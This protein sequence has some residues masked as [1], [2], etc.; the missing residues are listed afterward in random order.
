MQDIIDNTYEIVRRLEH[1]QQISIYLVRNINNNTLYAAKVRLNNIDVNQHE[2]QMCTNVS[3]INNPYIARLVNHG[4]GNIIFQGNIQNNQNYLIFDYYPH[5]LYEYIEKTG[6]FTEKHAKLIFDQIL[7]GV[8]ALHQA[9]ICHRYLAIDNILFDNNYNV[10]IIDFHIAALLQGN[11]NFNDNVGRESYSP[12]QMIEHLPYNGIKADIFSLGII[13]FIL[14]N[15]KTPFQSASYEDPLYKLIKNKEFDKYFLQVYKIMFVNNS[16][17][18]KNLFLKMVD[19]Y[20]NQ[21]PSIEVILNDPWFNEIRN[22]DNQQMGQ[23]NQDLRNELAQ[24]DIHIN[25]FNNQNNNIINNQNNQAQNNQNNQA[26]NNQ[27]QNNPN[28]NN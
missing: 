4:I 28:G 1:F 3:N 16:D 9:G 6:T 20:E 11:N 10:K 8:Q 5:S 23:L 19:F 21:R 22:L 17:E 14:V 12:P 27:N 7:N 2:I 18:F 13:L 26:Q 15:G 24:R 25:N